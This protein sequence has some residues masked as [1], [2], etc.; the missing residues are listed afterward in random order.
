MWLAQEASW[1]GGFSRTQKKKKAGVPGENEREYLSGC[2]KQ[3]MQIF[4]LGSRRKTM[5]L[6]TGFVGLSASPPANPP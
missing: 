4:R 3:K 2:F 1:K 5:S 6:A